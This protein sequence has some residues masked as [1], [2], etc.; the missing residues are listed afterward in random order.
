MDANNQN[1]GLETYRDYLRVL[2]RLQL[3]SRL[4]GKLDPSDVVQQTML[5]AHRDWDQFR[6]KT[7]GEKAA[8]LRKI[9]VRNLADEYRRYGRA[10]RAAG[11]EKSLEQS[12]NASSAR[13][14]AWL[15]SPQESPSG[16]VARQD[17]MLRL[18]A[19]LARLPDD[20]RLA[21]ELHHLKGLSWADVSRELG[22]SEPAVAG[23][24]RRGLKRLR[25]L[26]Q[27]EDEV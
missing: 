13:L 23:L 24:L 3:D 9:L 5:E 7:H 26:M 12:V 16:Q 15:A 14:E 1:A 19:M 18:A 6:G 22:R 25:K 20:Q 11:L 17:R 8:W 21:I 27:S 4:R 2:A 10:K